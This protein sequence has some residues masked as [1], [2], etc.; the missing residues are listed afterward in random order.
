MNLKKSTSKSLYRLVNVQLLTQAVNEIIKKDYSFSMIL[1]ESKNSQELFNFHMFIDP[2][3]SNLRVSD[4]FVTSLIS[5]ILMRPLFDITLSLHYLTYP[6]KKSTHNQSSLK[7][8]AQDLT[9]F[10]STPNLHSL[11]ISTLQGVYPLP[12]LWSLYSIYTY[13]STDLTTDP[14]NFGIRLTTLTIVPKYSLSS[15]ILS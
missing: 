8:I 1:N 12:K 5:S 13:L 15:L 11:L 9:S 14:V 4:Q 2:L 10:Q 3:K 7:H 6:S